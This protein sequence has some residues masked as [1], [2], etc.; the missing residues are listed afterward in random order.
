MNYKIAICEDSVTDLNRTTE[1]LNSW[2]TQLEIQY[3]V[4]TSSESL[5]QEYTKKNYHIFLLDIDLPGISG[6]DLASILR[7][8]NKK[9]I[10][11]FLTSFEDK[12]QK[13][14][15]VGAFRYLLKPVSE[16]ELTLALNKALLAL[17]EEYRVFI[18]KAEHQT[19]TILCSEINYIESL[20]RKM[21]IHQA[22]DTSTYN[23]TMKSTLDALPKA[24]FVQTHKAY[25]VNLTKVMNYQNSQLT[26]EDHS[27][28]PV[29]RMYCEQFLERYFAYINE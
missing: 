1:I 2:G 15:E 18:Y 14:F 8:N 23:G 28:V 26:L 7:K 13:A 27:T 19:K 16:E 3:D 11:I 20:G 10:I 22:G 5:L 21:M 29:S 4:Y 25:I 24:T 9:A 12:M 6:M 17:S